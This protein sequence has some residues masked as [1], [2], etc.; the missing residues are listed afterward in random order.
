MA[1]KMEDVFE[2][3]LSDLGEDFLGFVGAFFE[4]SLDDCLGEFFE[5][6]EKI[7][8]ILWRIFWRAPDS[9]ESSKFRRAPDF[10]RI[11]AIGQKPPHSH[12]GWQKQPDDTLRQ[13][14][15]YRS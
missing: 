10:R 12:R 3:V 6:S 8:K 14:A 5:D 15:S 2:D 13:P 4:N 1:Q 11:Q 7:L 9:G